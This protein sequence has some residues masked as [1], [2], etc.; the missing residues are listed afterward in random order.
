MAEAGNPTGTVQIGLD[1]TQFRAGTQAILSDIRSIMQGLSQFEKVSNQTGGALKGFEDASRSLK[2]FRAAIDGDALPALRRLQNQASASANSLSRVFQVGAQSNQA[3][4]GINR[5]TSAL[6]AQERQ[7]LRTADAMARAA[8]ASQRGAMAFRNGGRSSSGTSGRSVSGGT[9]GAR[10]SLDDSGAAARRLNQQADALFARVGKLTGGKGQSKWPFRDMPDPRNDPKQAWRFATPSAAQQAANRRRLQEIDRK[11]QEGIARRGGWKSV[12]AAR[13]EDDEMFSRREQYARR[14]SL[15]PKISA[16]TRILLR[17]ADQLRTSRA[18]KNYSG[19][20]DEPIRGTASLE[21]AAQLFARALARSSAAGVRI[22]GASPQS[23]RGRRVALQGDTA[24]DEMMSAIRSGKR[25][26]RPMAF[27]MSRN[28]RRLQLVEAALAEQLDSAGL[29]RRMPRSEIPLLRGGW[30]ADAPNPYRRSSIPRLRKMRRITVGAYSAGQSMDPRET[31]YLGA[32]SGVGAPG[33]GAAMLAHEIK[34]RGRAGKSLPLKAVSDALP[35]YLRGGFRRGPSGKTRMSTAAAERTQTLGNLTSLAM[36]AADAKKLTKLIR[37]RLRAEEE[38]LGL[39]AGSVKFAK[40]GMLG[41]LGE[42]QKKTAAK[43]RQT[44]QRGYSTFSP[45]PGTSNVRDASE[46]MARSLIRSAAAGVTTK[47]YG[48]RIGQKLADGPDGLSKTA[49]RELRQYKDWMTALRRY[50]NNSL[51]LPSER[52]DARG[53]VHRTYRYKKVAGFDPTSEDNRLGMSMANNALDMISS[54]DRPGRVALAPNPYYG[55]KGYPK[56]LTRLKMVPV[57][58]YAS[59]IESGSHGY[60]GALAGSGETWAGG[61]APLGGV[62][63]TLIA[64]ELRR[65]D[66]FRRAQGPA[67]RRDMT[68]RGSAMAPYGGFGQLEMF[69]I[70]QALGA[71]Q[72]MGAEEILGNGKTRRYKKGKDLNSEDGSLAWTPWRAKNIIRGIRRSLPGQIAALRG[73]GGESI[74]SNIKFNQRSGLVPNERGR[75]AMLEAEITRQAIV[76]ATE[77]GREE[78]P[79]TA[80]IE[81]AAKT[82]ARGIV[83]SQ[84][85][86]VSVRRIPAFPGIGGHIAADSLGILDD[87][88]AQNRGAL[89][90]SPSPFPFI[91]AS[92]GRV[93][94]MHAALRQMTSG[95]RGGFIAQIGNQGVPEN[96]QSLIPHIPVGA[97]STREPGQFHGYLGSL[98][99]LGIPGIGSALLAAEI[100]RRV[101]M[102]RVEAMGTAR[103][104]FLHPGDIMDHYREI[105]PYKIPS[106]DISAADSGKGFYTMAGLTDAMGRPVGGDVASRVPGALSLQGP[107]Q[108]AMIAEIR[109]QIAILEKEYGLPEGSVRFAKRSSLSSIAASTGVRGKG[110]DSTVGAT[111]KR[112]FE[113]LAAA[114]DTALG[115]YI[116]EMMQGLKAGRNGTVGPRQVAKALGKFQEDVLGSFGIGSGKGI[117][118]MRAGF[119]ALPADSRRRIAKSVSS[120][121]GDLL[122]DYSERMAPALR[123]GGASLAPLGGK[124]HTADLKTILT[125]SQG[126]LLEELAATQAAAR[127][128]RRRS[129]YSIPAANASR[130]RT[131]PP[132]S[133]LE[134]VNGLPVLGN[135]IFKSPAILQS[136]KGGGQGAY[137]NS[138]VAAL[139][140]QQFMPRLDNNYGSLTMSNILQTHGAFGLAGMNENK[141]VRGKRHQ[142]PGGENT[143]FGHV[144][145]D[146]GGSQSATVTLFN[147][148]KTMLHEIEHVREQ[149]AHLA[150]VKATGGQ[151]SGA[152]Y[153]AQMKRRGFGTSELLPVYDPGT[154]ELMYVPKGAPGVKVVKDGVLKLPDGALTKSQFM[155]L[156]IAKRGGF[157]RATIT[158]AQ[159]AEFDKNA[160]GS[161][162]N[163]QRHFMPQARMGMESGFGIS[164]MA[165]LLAFSNRNILPGES[166]DQA[167]LRSRLTNTGFFPGGAEQAVIAAGGINAIRPGL[168]GTSNSFIAGALPAYEQVAKGPQRTA[169]MFGARVQA[170]L[171]NAVTALAAGGDEMSLLG[172]AAKALVR[173]TQAI[174]AKELKATF[175]SLSSTALADFGMVLDAAVGGGRKL[176]RDVP[177]GAPVTEAPGTANYV[178]PGYVTDAK[179]KR[180]RKANVPAAPVGG[181]VTVR[182][183]TPEGLQAVSAATHALTLSTAGVSAAALPQARAN[184]RQAR[185][186]ALG[187]PARV[188]P[189]IEAVRRS[190]ALATLAAE[191]GAM[192][193]G[194]HKEALKGM[195]QPHMPN[196]PLFD[197]PK[198]TRTGRGRSAGVA[199]SGFSSSTAIVPA[200]E[201]NLPYQQH[202]ARIQSAIFGDSFGMGGKPR[203]PQVPGGNI[204]ADPTNPMDNF[205][206]SLKE[207]A[208]GMKNY[209]MDSKIA[210][211]LTQDFNAAIQQ[212]RAGTLNFGSALRTIGDSS[213]GLLFTVKDTIKFATAITLTQNAAGAISQSIGHLTGGFIQFNSILEQSRVGFTTLFAQG[214]DSLALAESRAAGMIEKMKQF[215]NVTPFRFPQLEE[216]AIR[217]K[218]FGL[219]MGNIIRMDPQTGKFTGYMQAIG[220]AVAALG[221][222]DDKI[223]RIT[224]AL[225][226]MNSAGR[227]YQNDMMQLANAGIAGYEILAEKLIAELEAK[228]KDMT[229][230]DKKTLN[231]LYSNRIEA[232]RKLTSK[233]AISGKGAVQ[234]I[235]AGLEDRYGGGME[236]LSKTMMGAFSTIADMSQSLV[237]T[238]TG[239]LYNAIRDVVVQLA[240]YLQGPEIM[241]FFLKMREGMLGLASGLSEAIPAA[242]KI[243]GDALGF[244]VAMFQKMFG[245]GNGVRGGLS[246]IIDGFRTLGD[247]LKNDTV[248]AMAFAAIAAKA[249]MS[250]ITANPLIVTIGAIIALLGSLRVAYEQNFLGIADTV[251][252]LAPAFSELATTISEQIVPAITGFISGFGSFITMLASGVIKVFGPIIAGIA[253]AFGG[254][255]GIL[256]TIAPILGFIVAMMVTKQLAVNGFAMAFEKLGAAIARTSG[257]MAVFGANTRSWGSRSV[258]GAGVGLMPVNSRGEVIRGSAAEK[259][260][261]GFVGQK[262]IATPGLLR[263]ASYVSATGPVATPGGAQTIDT[264][265]GKVIAR[266]AVM[267]P[268]AVTQL[269]STMGTEL[270]ANKEIQQA[271]K[272]RQKMVDRAWIGLMPSEEDAYRHMT[273]QEKFNAAEGRGTMLPGVLRAR[274]SGEG[275]IGVRKQGNIQLA[276]SSRAERKAAAARLGISL[277]EM[278]RRLSG[279]SIRTPEVIDQRTGQVLDPGGKLTVPA[280]LLRPEQL[281]EAEKL[282]EL[283]RQMR[284]KAIAEPELSRAQ[285]VEQERQRRADLRRKARPR[286]VLPKARTVIPGEVFST[287]GDSAT[288]RIPG[289]PVMRRLKGI[290]YDL[291]RFGK[292]IWG[293]VARKERYDLAGLSTERGI[294]P[295]GTIPG[296]NRVPTSGP[297]P[298]G[299]FSTE[300]GGKVGKVRK[301]LNT[302]KGGRNPLAAFG[303]EGAGPTALAPRRIRTQDIMPLSAFNTEQDIVGGGKI[304]QWKESLRTKALVARDEVMSQASGFKTYWKDKHGSQA[305]AAAAEAAGGLATAFGAATM[306]AGALAGVFS[307]ELGATISQI[308]MLLLGFGQMVTMATAAITAMGGRAGI[309]S[310]M[311]ALMNFATGPMGIAAVVGIVALAF[312][313]LDNQ[314]KATTK[315]L[316]DGAKKWKDTFE[317]VATK[318][319]ESVSFDTAVGPGKD[320]IKVMGMT[321]KG[322]SLDATM[323]KE[324]MDELVKQGL[325]EAKLNPLVGPNDPN[326]YSY[327][328]TAAGFKAGYSGASI[329]TDNASIDLP[330]ILP[331]PSESEAF[332]KS[333][334]GMLYGDGIK[335]YETDKARLQKAFETGNLSSSKWQEYMAAGKADVAKRGLLDVTGVNAYNFAF[336][337]WQKDNPAFSDAG[338][339]GILKG[340]GFAN[341]H[342]GAAGKAGL[343]DETIFNTTE[344]LKLLNA[345]LEDAQKAAQ[346]AAKKLNELFDPFATAFEQ[347]MARA[348]QIVQKVFQMEQDQLT[349]KTSDALS[350]VTALHNGEVSR[351]G[352]LEEQRKEQE[353]MKALQDAQEAAARATLG[354]FDA[355]VDPID[356]AIAAREASQ[357]LQKAE[358]DAAMETL[359]TDIERTKNSVEYAKTEEFWANKKAQLDADQAERSRLIQERA[360]QLLKDIKEGKITP[361]KAQAEFYAMF[362][363]VGIDMEGIIASGQLG[364]ETLADAFGTA[365]V[366]SFESLA[367]KI[368]STIGTVVRAG[369]AAAIAATNVDA[370]VKKLDQIDKGTDKV[371][372]SKIIAERERMKGVIEQTK[373]VL[374]VKAAQAVSEGNFDLLAQIN[375]Y[376]GYLKLAGDKIGSMQAW[377][378]LKMYMRKDFD[379]AFSSIYGVFTSLYDSLGPLATIVPNVSTRKGGVARGGSIGAGQYIVG[380]RG[381]EMLQMYPDGGGYVVPNH[382]LPASMRSSYGALKA[383]GGNQYQGRAAGGYVGPGRDNYSTED[384]SA[385][386][387][388][389][390]KYLGDPAG[391]QQQ[392]FNDFMESPRNTKAQKNELARRY[393]KNYAKYVRSK[394]GS[395]GGGKIGFGRVAMSSMGTLPMDGG[396]DP[397]VPWTPD[398]ETPVVPEPFVCPP[399]YQKV[400]S[401]GGYSCEKITDTTVVIPPVISCPIGTIPRW[402]AA[403]K[404]WTCVPV[405][406]LW[407]E[408]GTPELPLPRAI[409]LDARAYALANNEMPWQMKDGVWSK[410]KGA[411]TRAYAPYGFRGGG[412]TDVLNN[413]GYLNPKR[414]SSIPGPKYGGQTAAVVSGGTGWKKRGGWLSKLK[415]LGP[416][417]TW[418]NQDIRPLDHLKPGQLGTSLRVGMPETTPL[419]KVARNKWTPAGMNQRGLLS[420]FT[421]NGSLM[422]RAALKVYPAL[423]YGSAIL[424]AALTGLDIYEQQQMGADYWEA[425]LNRIQAENAIDEWWKANRKNNLPDSILN[426]PYFTQLSAMGNMSIEGDYK[427]AAVEKALAAGAI[428]FPPPIKF[429]DEER[430]YYESSKE[431]IARGL[432]RGAGAIGGAGLGGLITATLGVASG[433]LALPIGLAIGSVLSAMGSF[434]GGALYDILFGTNTPFHEVR[435]LGNQNDIG[436]LPMLGNIAGFGADVMGA[437][438][439]AIMEKVT[440]KRQIKSPEAKNNLRY[441]QG[442]FDPELLAQGMD[443]AAMKAQDYRPQ[444]IK[445]PDPPGG[446]LKNNYALIAAGFVPRW[447]SEW[448]DSGVPGVRNPLTHRKVMPEGWTPDSLQARIPG[449][450]FGGAVNPYMPYLVGE[451]GPELM[452]PSNSGYMLPNTGLKALQAPGDLRAAGGAATINA[453][454]TINNPVVSDAADI[455]KLAEKVSAAQVRTLRAAGFQ[456]PG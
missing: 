165:S 431:P 376:Q 85:G 156:P 435:G 316:Q 45:S 167:T 138:L 69:G 54:G 267:A 365:F 40:K 246:L 436:L 331:T 425:Q 218:A 241:A 221:G 38:A 292:G 249:L 108:L 226:Q 177:M 172:G 145:F 208:N 269:G 73:I 291:Q 121:F 297:I 135:D 289:S 125:G 429:N 418:L 120:M 118:G 281:T 199:T 294:G 307:A 36:S 224:Y 206:P 209:V 75:Q 31:G 322:V 161:H 394:I 32:L 228:G 201:T 398:P 422:N 24:L 187:L 251:D 300:G 410:I 284:E 357:A 301:W 393:P 95:E 270:F 305:T 377:D 190:L 169:A 317:A 401:E 339:S 402:D 212:A 220:D 384:P 64:G 262:T 89:A 299:A 144:M 211:G 371:Q 47:E 159:A 182:A 279:E 298:L 179:G 6:A 34:R 157:E 175:G 349:A 336:K 263:G 193:E 403:A 438:I 244:F 204:L 129:G 419:S 451:R 196:N 439:G 183:L 122:S 178:D 104:R 351:L 83:H 42:L 278:D 139:L 344:K 101:S 5:V 362:G 321:D 345:S 259:G 239:P 194:P 188:S 382:K 18:Q 337:A 12:Y 242:A 106:L 140:G 8:T 367:A 347:F 272:L 413:S 265:T 186:G 111:S 119:D 373:A 315:E 3:V 245:S 146:P 176:T 136:L 46:R 277:R 340:Q 232:I 99:G 15:A 113:P 56:Q 341:S 84:I 296:S 158:Q 332:A 16:K 164:Q 283:D 304:A 43:R 65:R 282:A 26:Q 319:Q 313:Q 328:P 109:K 406:L 440:G 311:S 320:S 49:M 87:L 59:S 264:R 342:L 60:L 143:G 404:Q 389:S 79:P 424:T 198:G 274:R 152:A 423:K 370:I 50:A 355:Q 154:G 386:F 252:Q 446:V 237:A 290:K 72:Q 447:Y 35:L 30:V 200:G 303:T 420:K 380:E 391:F 110:G 395:G 52:T 455:D 133:G 147:T 227:V 114:I 374:A 142:M 25:T 41:G 207:M 23:A 261:T 80:S 235:M 280:R 107:K 155:E 383:G 13:D 399:G 137:N 17:K 369:V 295:T 149:A 335:N 258:V 117:A 68:A 348:M 454:V 216:A 243:G 238:M 312:I 93:G 9:R 392:S 63:G 432:F 353:R 416:I 375:Q 94:M 412:K 214:G 70:S 105:L 428:K 28:Q 97:Y 444:D 378:P 248:K 19:Y 37:A 400:W 195:L 229:N 441:A 352:V 222:G 437:L 385:S 405:D 450:A 285:R 390:L 275:D 66:R 112:G 100:K 414:A 448:E 215:A 7:A 408:F 247:L 273:E 360:Q 27:R 150:S 257:Q 433:G 67:D 141:N 151:T 453:S 62:G 325:F 346:D 308:G 276:R 387:Q 124:S 234:A 372:G 230:E 77:I 51:P 254:F 22:R 334:N 11:F 309:A 417:S 407:P 456:R 166:R 57:G 160:Q 210:R 116:N 306:A 363:D 240:T 202:L 163:I 330:N 225:G 58:A 271:N 286:V 90:G 449:K 350:N 260:G 29:G 132:G 217:M 123:R 148:V 324:K 343:V 20:T 310:A 411:V 181:G 153:E 88:I 91:G 213:K 356:A 381:P 361:A 39:P 415:G 1:A 98:S 255:G 358:Q 130:F 443:S 338:I 128:S 174:P 327:T 197:L 223:M 364:G 318:T 180:R 293:T 4:S 53:G 445:L 452:I 14:G 219:E 102:G 442:I 127:P 314:V 76:R 288:G 162:A 81:E 287:E 61:R 253:N 78:V 55:K 33:V 359:A 236:R 2:S 74:P 354:L 82:L 21:D 368:T 185:T 191:V 134:Y 96:L 326:A 168:A 10:S 409:L 388:N 115:A 71:Y 430:A 333:I 184:V 266:E 233:G 86:G 131:A 379:N 329:I 302:L 268:I 397:E 44:Y 48:G 103:E 323:T 427:N 171:T 421:A 426:N 192:P 126:V 366:N 205:A 170:G 256:Q 173:A 231:D 434:G 250:A 92:Q 396:G 203:R 189:D